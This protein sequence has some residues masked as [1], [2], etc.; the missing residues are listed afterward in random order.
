MYD[1]YEDN[2]CYYMSS[3]KH[4]RIL[5]KRIRSACGIIIGLCMFAIWGIMGSADMERISLTQF[6]IHEAITICVMLAAIFVGARCAE[7]E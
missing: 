2:T 4:R 7:E 3:R 6:F 1:H 5:R